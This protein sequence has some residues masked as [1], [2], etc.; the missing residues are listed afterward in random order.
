MVSESERPPENG[1]ATRLPPFGGVV[2]QA[3]ARKQAEVEHGGVARAEW[4]WAWGWA[5]AVVALSCLPFVYA[6]LAAPPGLT[7]AGFIVNTQDG[8]SYLAK[9]REGYEGAWLF[10]LA[11]TPE[12]QRGLFVFTLYLALGHLARL[13]SLP[14]ALVFHL[15]RAASGLFLLLTVYRLAAE[16]TPDRAARR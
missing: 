6:Y 9:M 13:T 8:N 2:A 3:V 7:F 5:L 12:D 4:R 16:L 14:L 1:G 11:F 15:A 10:R